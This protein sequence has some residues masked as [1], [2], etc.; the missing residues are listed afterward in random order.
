MMLDTYLSLSQQCK[1][2]QWDQASQSLKNYFNQQPES[3]EFLCA[4][5]ML[6]REQ[7]QYENALAWADRAVKL[8]P[9]YALGYIEAALALDLMGERQEALAL[10]TAYRLKQLDFIH[11]AHLTRIELL[12]DHQREKEAYQEIEILLSSPNEFT[13]ELFGLLFYCSELLAY[14]LPTTPEFL[15]WQKNI[16]PALGREGI[17]QLTAALS[18]SHESDALCL[19]RRAQ[20]LLPNDAD[21]IG[22]LGIYYFHK[23]QFLLAGKF[24]SEG[25]FREPFHA[26][27]ID[28]YYFSTLVRIGQYQE[29]TAL[30]DLMHTKNPLKD[31]HLAL[32]AECTRRLNKNKECEILLRHLL[33]QPQILPAAQVILWQLHSEK[34]TDTLITELM[35]HAHDPQCPAPYLYFLAA[36]LKTTQATK[37]K[38]Y[39]QLAIQKDPFFPHALDWEYLDKESAYYKPSVIN[40]PLKRAGIFSP[41]PSEGDAWPTETQLE[42]IHFSLGENIDHFKDW[43]DQHAPDTLD[44]GGI[45]LLPFLFH[46][47]IKKLPNTIPYY[48]ILSGLWKK[49]FYENITHWRVALPTLNALQE[50]HI[51]VTLIKGCALSALLYKDWGSRPMADI[52]ILISVHDV[53]QACSILNQHGWAAIDLVVPE[54]LRFQYAITFKSPQGGNL[55]LHWRLGDNF[56][57]DAY[58]ENE[59]ETTPELSL[60]NHTFYTLSPSLHFLHTLT[61]GIAWDYSSPARWVMDALLIIKEWGAQLNWEVISTYAKRY[62]LEP[63]LFHG[64]KFLRTHF[65]FTQSSLPAP[66]QFSYS[67]EVALLFE[68]RLH[69]KRILCSH[70]QIMALHQN[71][72][73][74]FNLK[75]DEDIC[76]IGGKEK[77]TTQKWCQDHH[78]A[79]FS[80]LD[81]DLIDA[82][83]RKEKKDILII[84]DANQTGWLHFHISHEMHS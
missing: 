75:E 22:A 12:I 3:P 19:I 1:E 13:N 30:A 23:Q 55:D 18:S 76:I 5:A 56:I 44:S 24:L 33:S 49:S 40:D 67:K 35:Q 51:K 9:E 78:I 81:G 57:W 73:T 31:Y 66:E 26:N 61:H 48:F 4:A 72:L 37:A 34:V 32:Y 7:G 77:E 80:E 10:L 50:A 28:L 8:N 52:D 25:K 6:T 63:V 41:R 68:L 11:L 27:T 64:L 60:F 36:H 65:P 38:E 2:G 69:P 82:Y 84:I 46:Q 54:R 62:Q 83:K 17:P 59:L 43:S 29:A 21:V 58:P 53:H 20:R 14:P 39:L 70:D 15:H 45:R 79:W 71:V 74:R 42:I 47:Q 16:L